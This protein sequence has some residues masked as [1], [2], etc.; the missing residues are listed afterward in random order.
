[1]LVSSHPL[2]SYRTLQLEIEESK[3]NFRESSMMVASSQ[4]MS[5]SR[6]TVVR[7]LLYADF[8][9]LLTAKKAE[10]AEKLKS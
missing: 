10:K 7:N 6:I 5:V 8:N 9:L 2:I 4:K 3:E 1:M